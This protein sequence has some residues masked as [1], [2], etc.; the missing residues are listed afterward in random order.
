MTVAPVVNARGVLND[1]TLQPA[2]TTVAPG[3][4]LRVD[5]LNL[6]PAAGAKAEGFPL[7]TKLADVEVLINNRPAPLFS[8]S[9]S[10]IVCQVPLEVAAG[11]ANLVV[12]RGEATSRVA[13]FTVNT[14]A[15][16]L[17]S[18]ARN[19]FG[20]AAD[21]GSGARMALAAAG[22]G[23]T[24]PRV[25]TGEP[26]PAEPHAEPRQ[27]VRVYLNGL[28]AEPDA[29][30]SP[31][32]VGEFEI[33]F[34][35]PA[36]ARAGDVVQVYSAGRLANLLTNGELNSASLEYLPLPE[37]LSELRFFQGSDLS[38]FYVVAHGPRTEG[39][40][41]A[42]VFDFRQA[43]AK[44][45]EGC[46]ASANP[47]AQTPLL[48]PNDNPVL[49]SFLGPAQGQP[50]QGVSDKV[51]LLNPALEAPVQVQ[52]PA[53]ASAL[54]ATADGN[55]VAV[56]PGEPPRAVRIDVAS[57]AV[58]ELET[59]GAGGGGAG[60]GGGGAGP[61]QGG[62]I[63]PGALLN[64]QVDLGDG[65]N[66]VV[67]N[68]VQYAPN[69]FAVVVADDEDKPRKGKL[70]LINLRGD[71]TGTREFPGG[72]IPLVAPEQPQR[73]GPGGQVPGRPD[74]P[75]RRGVTAFFDGQTRILYVPSLS[76]D[77]AK[78]ALAAFPPEEA[79][80]AALALP[81]GWFF[82]NCTVNL[83][84]FN[85]ELARRVALFGTRNF[86]DQFRQQCPAQG[87][88]LV[89]LNNRNVTAA[90]L[91]GAGHLNVN[92][93]TGDLNDFVFGSNVDA[94]QQNTADTLYVLDSVTVSALRFDLPSGVSSFAGISPVR[95]LNLLIATGRSRVVGDAGFV[96]FDLE[97]GETQLL[98]TPAGFDTVA[99]VGI[100]P[101]TRKLVARGIRSNP[102][103]SA[104]LVYDLVSRDVQIV[105]NP[106]GV[107]WV[108]PVPAAAG[109]PG[110]PAIQALRPNP[111]SNTV[112]ALATN[113]DRKAV[114]LLLLRV[115]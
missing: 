59:P 93:A 49:M 15:P 106:D 113:S 12:R 89:E 61:G 101:A 95:D 27:V 55:V 14:T 44:P 11:L 94:A 69:I 63:N 43:S 33:S 114:G 51:L 19:G 58:E 22:L 10:R 57:G 111:K 68:P 97:R 88:I 16:S 40:F 112:A 76:P 42:H 31:E 2:P 13:R 46:L 109:Q 30:L 83:A 84:I 104:F 72:L 98:N 4:I 18:K 23:A 107:A 6:S 26:G 21:R 7:P 105:K 28:A 79:N 50:P 62:Q 54:A 80:T 85:L 38:G 8:V 67:S 102:A 103:G 35:K 9:P 92:A 66:K 29:R 65:L 53:A 48:A 20:A 5:G 78:H 56:M 75:D 60:G 110:Q 91:P 74:A 73:P 17:Q 81:E 70:A 39:C 71:V 100:F 64:L 115:P 1:F 87:F 86:E 37:A 47:N 24:D 90:R 82:A 45:V 41:S 36:A 108:G 96:V 25:P 34:D 52:L 99:M 32:R 77:G 3:A